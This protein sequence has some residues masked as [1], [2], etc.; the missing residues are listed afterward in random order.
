MNQHT[1]GPWIANGYD[2]RQDALRHGGRMIAYCGPSHTPAAEYPAQCRSQDEANARLIAAAP[3]LLNRLYLVLPYLE[4]LR[5]SEA[6][7]KSPTYKPGVLKKMVADTA[8][9][10]AKAE[11][12]A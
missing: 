12:R 9:A 11:G 6:K 3:E 7:S 5:D 2:V 1:P 10:I 4:D 8:A